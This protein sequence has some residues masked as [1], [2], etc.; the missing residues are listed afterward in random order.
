MNSGFKKLLGK[1][2]LDG[3]VQKHLNEIN[4]EELERYKS[5]TEAAGYA[6]WETDENNE[7]T[8]R[9]CIGWELLTGMTKQDCKKLSWKNAIHPDYREDAREQFEAHRFRNDVYEVTYPIRLKTGEYR[10]FLVR[11]VPVVSKSNP[12]TRWVRFG[13]DID[14]RLTAQEALVS[15]L[16]RA[17]QADE[18]K[19]DFLA[20]VSHELRTP[21]TGILGFGELL[22]D[23]VYGELTENQKDAVKRIQMCGTHLLGMIDQILDFS[24]IE[25]GRVDVKPEVCRVDKVVQQVADMVRPLSVGRNLNFDVECER[26]LVISTDPQKLRQVLVNLLTNAVKF[27]QRGSVG[28]SVK[29]IDQQKVVFSVT[30]TGIGI[31]EAY[32]DKIF[33]KFWQV[34]SGLTRNVN[35]AGLGLAI[36]KKFVTALGGDIYL[37]SSEGDAGRPSGTTFTVILPI[38]MPLTAVDIET[39]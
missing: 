24:Q 5:I 14:D 22:V 38:N 29:K 33:E 15:A 23:D 34:K 31:P 19:S 36:V 1:V 10:R 35:G 6:L 9:G 26:A 27:T 2:F 30:D 39:Y 13:V 28:I 4:E 20:V 18:I 21:L 11:V 12:H 3:V 37:T 32:Q 25:G 17:K 7:I 8:E 16:E